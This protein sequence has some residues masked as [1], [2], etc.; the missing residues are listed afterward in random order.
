M[1]WRK[2]NLL[3]NYLIAVL[4]K[5]LNNSYKFRNSYNIIIKYSE[6]IYLYI[7]HHYK[8]IY[9]TCSAELWTNGWGKHKWFLKVFSFLLVIV[10]TFQMLSLFPFSPLHPTHPDHLILLYFASI[11]VF[12][13]TPNPIPTSL[14]YHPLML[15]FQAFTGP[16]A[17]PHSDNR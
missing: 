6:I 10:F 1:D 12:H 14:L 13:N 15:W 3:V 5:D 4:V 7:L 8:R 11:P 2:C 16:S 17:W 9:V